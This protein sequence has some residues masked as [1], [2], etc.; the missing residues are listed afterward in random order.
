MQAIQAKNT[1]TFPA[2]FMQTLEEN[3]R[4]CVD[5][6]PAVQLD[7]AK[8]F[9]Q[10]D[11]F[12]L[13]FFGEPIPVTTEEDIPA[14]LA[15]V[16]AIWGTRADWYDKRL[17]GGDWRK[18]VFE[19]TPGEHIAKAAKR[20]WS[21]A[22]QMYNEVSFDEGE[23]KA[24]QLWFWLKFNDFEHIVNPWDEESPKKITD[25][26][27]AEVVAREERRRQSPEYK[28]LQEKIAGMQ[29]KITEMT[30]NIGA[31]FEM[32]DSDKIVWLKEIFEILDYRSID[33]DYAKIRGAFANMDYDTAGT[34]KSIKALREALNNLR[35]AWTEMLTV[36]LLDV[37]NY[38]EKTQGNPAA[39]TGVPP[40]LFDMLNK[41]DNIK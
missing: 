12:V 40:M 34:D 13:N 5:E 28:A 11:E 27:M 29:A 16:Q 18:V 38:R 25:T 2:L 1:Y 31:F 39:G 36:R 32:E 22:H 41:F 10:I 9:I 20:A 7:A 17:P 3:L 33:V 37:L 24:Q 8:E 23:S 30:E 14:T 4:R 35:R 6:I 26:F 21:E 19:G 15:T